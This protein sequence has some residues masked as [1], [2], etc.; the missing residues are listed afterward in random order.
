MS[1]KEKLAPPRPLSFQG[2]AGQ[3]ME[4]SLAFWTTCVRGGLLS[5][6]CLGNSAWVR[7]WVVVI[8]L[9]RQLI[10]ISVSPSLLSICTGAAGPGEAQAAGRERKLS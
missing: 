6:G 5:Q 4:M 7:P 3:S 1:E 8:P 9:L 2:C 10:A